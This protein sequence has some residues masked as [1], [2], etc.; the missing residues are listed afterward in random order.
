VEKEVYPMDSN[1]IRNWDGTQS[2]EPEAIHQPRDEEGIAGLIRRALDEGKRVKPVG[3]ALSWSDIIDVPA[4]ALRFDNMADVLDVDGDNRRVRLQAGARLDH[5]NEALA[6]HALAFDNFGSIITQTVA[7]Y[8]ATASHG[9]G[10]RT[11]M[12]SAYIDSMRL[13]DGLGQVHE[14][15]ADHEPELF[16]A[17]RVNLGCLGVVTE[18]TLRCVAAFDLEERLELVPFDT[19]LADLDSYIKNNDYC[20]LWWLPYTDKVQVYSFNKT[21]GPRGGF[22]ITGFLDGTGLSGVLFTTL[23]ALGRV[24][25]RAIPFIHDAVQTIHFRPRRRTDRSDKVIKVSSSIPIHQETEYAIPIDQAAQ[26]IDETRQLVLKA[27]YRVNFP[28]EVRFVAADDIPLSPASGRDSCF[29]GA[30]V[31]SLKWAPHLFAAFEELMHDYEGRPHWG[32]TFART[33]QELRALYPDYDTFDRLRRQCDPH[34]LFR[35]SFVERVFPA[36]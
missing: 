21:T 29:I 22:G 13:V 26:A 9:T 28:M 10:A 8:I 24:I 31:S 20:K 32:K 3:S 2:W 4:L 12:L 36:A 27:D 35:N 5:V 19:L 11:P 6:G 7:G 30:Y 15:D 23:I 17:A 18:L 34:G 25:P 1:K 16:S 33:S 14:L